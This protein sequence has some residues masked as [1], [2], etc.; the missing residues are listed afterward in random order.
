M[1]KRIVVCIPTYKRPDGLRRLLDGLSRQEFPPECEVRVVVVDNEGST[2]TRAICDENKEKVPI[3][4]IYV[5]EK[6]RGLSH[7]RNR[8][9]EIARQLGEFLIFID[10]DELPRE[11][12]LSRLVSCQEAYQADAVS[13]PVVPHFMSNVPVWIQAG[14]FFDRE[15]HE[16]GTL[17][18]ESRTGNTLVRLSVFDTIDGFNDRFAL[19]GGEDADFFIRLYRSGGR[20]IWCNEAVVEEWVPAQRACLKW[21]LAR[22]YRAG[23]TAFLLAGHEG[24]ARTIVRGVLRVCKGV[25]VVIASAAKGKPQAVR[26]MQKIM[27]GAGLIAGA[28]GLRY[29]E[30]GTIHPV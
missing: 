29:E 23:T 20:I 19:T 22:A 21:L 10:D 4:L 12:W 1:Q 28:I 8:A 27:N 7:V 2:L 13:G 17:L 15:R 14:L 6:Q 18:S 11:Q 26:G 24:R 25:Y 16:T 9:I 30:Y 5:A 3:P